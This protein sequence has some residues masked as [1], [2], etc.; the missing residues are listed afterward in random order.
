MFFHQDREI[1]KWLGDERPRDQEPLT[2]KGNY[3][4]GMAEEDPILDE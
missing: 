1:V 3:P 2:I 4:Q